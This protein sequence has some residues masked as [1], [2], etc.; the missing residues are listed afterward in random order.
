MNTAMKNVAVAGE[1]F[2]FKSHFDF[3]KFF[4]EINQSKMINSD[5]LYLEHCLASNHTMP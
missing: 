3:I 4:L 2:I 5:H 1:K